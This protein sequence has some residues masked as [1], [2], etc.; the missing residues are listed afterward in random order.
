MEVTKKAYETEL[1]SHEVE[2]QK[3]REELG[4]YRKGVSVTQPTNAVGSRPLHPSSNFSTTKQSD[5]GVTWS[6]FDFLF[7]TRY[8]RDDFEEILRV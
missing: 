3:L 2:I 8:H 6:L 4:S 7:G 1:L 5:V